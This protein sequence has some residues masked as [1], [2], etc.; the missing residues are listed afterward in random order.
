MQEAMP[1][2]PGLLINNARNDD[3][4]GPAVAIFLMKLMHE[5]QTAVTFKSLEMIP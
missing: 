3:H 5:S 1:V 2:M 4:D